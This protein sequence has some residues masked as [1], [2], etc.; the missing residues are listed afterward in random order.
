M[1]EARG[2]LVDFTGDE[3]LV[4]HVVEAETGW[5]ERDQDRGYAQV[6]TGP[7]ADMSHVVER[8]RDAGIEG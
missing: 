8:I 1:P 2:R 4:G 3:S 5:G 7:M 6:A